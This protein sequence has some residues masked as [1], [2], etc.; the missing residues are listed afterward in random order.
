METLLG[1]RDSSSTVFG[2]S[3]LIMLFALRSRL[4]HYHLKCFY[5]FAFKL[6][7]VSSREDS[8][9]FYWRDI[10]LLKFKLLKFLDRCSN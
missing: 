6:L 3:L 10:K 8:H 1:H 7:T 9:K 4:T 2:A 5:Y